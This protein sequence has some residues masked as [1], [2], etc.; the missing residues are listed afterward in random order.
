MAEALRASEMTFRALIDSTA[1]AIFILQG[2]KFRYVNPAAVAIT[3]YPPAELLKMN[4]WDV[5]HPDFRR[6]SRLRELARQPGKLV[7]S[8]YELKII[9]KQGEER[10]VDLT[11]GLIYFQGK[12][13][14]LGTAFDITD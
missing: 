6:Q 9:T 11:V 10:W 8:R 3:G 2:K 12:P 7:T 1:S 13:S 4:F 5:A 14:L